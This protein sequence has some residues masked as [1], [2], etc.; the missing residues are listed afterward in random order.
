[1]YNLHQQHKAYQRFNQVQLIFLPNGLILG[2]V[3]GSAQ[4]WWCHSCLQKPLS[5]EQSATKATLWRCLNRTVGSC[6][7][8]VQVS[9]R[10][11]VLC[12]P[13]QLAGVRRVKW[14]TSQQS[15]KVPKCKLEYQCAKAMVYY[16]SLWC[17]PVTRPRQESWSTR[18]Q[19]SC[20]NWNKGVDCLHMLIRTEELRSPHIICE[21]RFNNKISTPII[22]FTK[23]TTII[24]MW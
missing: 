6:C 2:A 5:L 8:K 20:H 1:M 24:I 13:R 23:F 17:Q 18:M 3:D 22:L 15:T 10:P 7:K 21:T 14:G 12:Q 16:K 11:S 4:L 9:L 19:Q